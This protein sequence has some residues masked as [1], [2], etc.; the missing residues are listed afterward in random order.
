MS[1]HAVFSPSAAHRWMRC[2]GS[3]VLSKDLVDKPSPAAEEGIAAHELAA[4]CLR[5]GSMADDMAGV[6]LPDSGWIVDGEMA[7]YVQ[8]YC[9]I[10]REYAAGHQLLVE[11]RLEFSEAVGTPDQF[12]TADAVV[13][14]ADGTEIILI[15]LKYGRGV[16]VDAEDNEQLQMYAL[17]AL[18]EYG[19]L[20][21]WQR[22]RLV[23][24]QP[25]LRDAP[26][27]WD[28]S[29]EDLRAF[30][31]RARRAVEQVS[32]IC[33]DSMLVA[34]LNPGEKQCRWCRAKAT[35][36][37]LREEVKRVTG[38]DFDDLTQEPIAADPATLVPDALSLAMK[39]VPL[40]E[41]WC[42]AIRAETESQ[43]LKGVPVEGYKLVEGRK[44]AR[45]WTNPE[46]VE[47]L[48]KQS[49]RLRQDEMYEFKLIS[50]T[51]AEK[52]LK[53]SPKRWAKAQDLIT[54]SP[55]KLSVAPA[56]DKRPAITVAPA[57]FEDL[58]AVAT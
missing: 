15:D 39:S 56:S 27:E 58:T 13:L 32:E 18:E 8:R 2:P 57:E 47:T 55:G 21:D 52:L 3:V 16:E 51:A 50:P 37:A 29:V 30:Q 5:E 41:D 31:A 33:N 44:G 28:L 9:N 14:S 36:P 23:I 7:M 34:L 22:V 35:C 46:V 26:S 12:G 11:Q 45:Q 40:I 17:G 43:L 24:V 38:A 20:G 6:Q 19:I 10:V 25:R 4:L 48:F 1:D 49:F 42:A 53:K 54:Q